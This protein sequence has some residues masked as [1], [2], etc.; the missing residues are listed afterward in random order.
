MTI[1]VTGATGFIGSH[2]VGRLLEEGEDVVCMVRRTSNTEFLKKQGIELRVGDLR[3]K[4]LGGAVGGE[5]DTIY[6]LAAYY[7]FLGQKNLHLETNL[8]GTKKLFNAAAAAGVDHFIYCSTA[9][10]IG[11]VSCPG[12]V[13]E[14]ALYGPVYF[15]GRVKQLAEE[16]L[17]KQTSSTAWTIVRPSG[18]YGPRSIDDIGYYL[19]M[20]YAHKALTS[21]FFV[22]G[23]KG[24]VHFTFVK[25]I[26]Q[27]LSLAR[28]DAAKREIFFVCS[29]EAVTVNEVIRIICAELGR[30]PPRLSVPAWM[31][32]LG[33]AP[34]Q[35]LRWLFRKPKFFARVQAVR[36]AISCRSYL[37]EK[38]K[39]VLGFQPEYTIQ[40]GLAETIKWYREKKY[41]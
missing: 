26:V 38:A 12:P 21:R 5:V 24:I 17:Q 8:E 29:D 18:V 27:G 11:P 19:I 39:R 10:V 7:T 4:D 13:D 20:D 9:E 16:W 22:A 36:D 33:I 25:D 37:N 1:L 14:T 41:L 3:E 31:A 15:Y 32:Y 2:L 23:G 28:Q 6:H 30:S 34:L 35:F 40:N